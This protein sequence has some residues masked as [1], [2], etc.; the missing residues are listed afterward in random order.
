ML[1][2]SDC[3]KKFT[4]QEL[5]MGQ[6]LNLI[7]NPGDK[8]NVFEGNTQIDGTGTFIRT[9]DRVLI[10]IDSAGRLRVQSLGDAVNLQR[11]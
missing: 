4:F 9:N 1:K 11:A 10:W 2:K 7:F 6:A 8:I 3:T 5:S